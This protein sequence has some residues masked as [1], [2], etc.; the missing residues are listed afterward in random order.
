MGVPLLPGILA[1][2][3]AT[4]GG[5]YLLVSPAGSELAEFEAQHL[6]RLRRKMRRGGGL[7]MLLL[8][9]A[10]FTLFAAAEREAF[11]T[12]RWALVG[13]MAVLFVLMV[14]ALVDV[15]LTQKLRRFHRQKLSDQ[16]RE[17]EARRRAS[18]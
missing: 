11:A 12:M 15:R 9:A 18:R 5:Y 7:A 3:V 14:L 10:L 16:L 1:V 6:N 2:F 8:S 13:V 17:E 4:V